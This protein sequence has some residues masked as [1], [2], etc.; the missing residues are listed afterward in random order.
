MV[1][2][3]LRLFPPREQ[4]REILNLLR[5]VQRSAKAL[6]RCLGCGL[7]EEDSH[8]EAVL[9][10]EHWD[11]EP[12]LRRHIRSELYGRILLAIELSR[13]S[14]EIKFHYVKET[15][16]LELLQEVRGKSPDTGRATTTA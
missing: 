15:V 3:A 13:L 14:P 2:A 6:P 1:I 4:R 16:G 9:Y 12:E 11:G 10:L 7:F 8:D 5:T